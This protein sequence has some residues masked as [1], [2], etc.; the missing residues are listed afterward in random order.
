VPPPPPTRSVTLT[1][2]APTTNNDG[3]PL[4]DVVG[5]RISYG[6]SPGDLT[7]TISVDGSSTTT[8]VV[9]GMNAGTYY[10]VIAAVNAS[11]IASD[12]TNAVV[13]TVP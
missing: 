3:T 2:V 13:A 5:Y 9:S 10:F 11:G 7:T 12:P 1:W 4:T 6:T 8:W